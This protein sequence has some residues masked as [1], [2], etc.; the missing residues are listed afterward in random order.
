LRRATV[1][2]LPPQLV[3]PGQGF[4]VGLGPVKMYLDVL[5]YGQ[6][7]INEWPLKYTIVSAQANTASLANVLNIFTSVH[8]GRSKL[9]LHGLYYKRVTIINDDSSIISK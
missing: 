6:K 9:W 2:S 1:L 5:I 7:W 4:V 3:F 8:Y